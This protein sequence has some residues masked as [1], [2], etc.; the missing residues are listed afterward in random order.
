MLLAIDSN[1]S[2]YVSNMND[3]VARHVEK[4]FLARRCS[5]FSAIYLNSRATDFEKDK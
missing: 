3:L 5:T 4:T 1:Q 2:Q